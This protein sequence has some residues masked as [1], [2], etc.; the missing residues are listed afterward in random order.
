M[1][2]CRICGE[3]RRPQDSH[4]C[5]DNKLVKSISSKIK[6]IIPFEEGEIEERIKNFE[7]NE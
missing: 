6:K 5:S 4:R 2:I 1:R 3:M 7:E